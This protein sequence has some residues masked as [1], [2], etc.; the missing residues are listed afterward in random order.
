ME[1]LYHSVCDYYISIDYVTVSFSLLSLTSFSRSPNDAS[2]KEHFENVNS[3]L[4]HEMQQEQK[5]RT[6]RA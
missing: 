5:H 1:V 2:L 6:P 3:G 4:N